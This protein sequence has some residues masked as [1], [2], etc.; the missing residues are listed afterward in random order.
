[1]RQRVRASINIFDV[2]V[3]DDKDD[4]LKLGDEKANKIYTALFRGF[5]SEEEKHRLIINV[6]TNTKSEIE[7]LVKDSM[8]ANE[9]SDMYN[10]IDSGSRGSYSNTTQIAGMKGLVQ[11]QVE[12]LSN[13][14]S[15]DVS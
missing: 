10:M 13:F 14:L 1:M 12:T 5:L 7:N 6:W 2:K 8:K 11:T 15:S 9:G 3:P 4:L